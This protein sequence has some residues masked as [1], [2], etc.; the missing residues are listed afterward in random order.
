[1]E[2]VSWA[3]TAHDSSRDPT[4]ITTPTTPT[5]FDC[6]R[7][8]RR[9]STPWSRCMCKGQR[10]PCYGLTVGYRNRVCGMKAPC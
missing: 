3:D 7:P 9:H 4:E 10:L 1:M 2:K 6:G 5:P 8:S